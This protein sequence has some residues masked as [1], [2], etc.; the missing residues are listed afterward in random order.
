MK[1]IE[2]DVVVGAVKQVCS[3]PM[4]RQTMI[5]TES[6]TAYTKRC[7]K[8]TSPPRKTWNLPQYHRQIRASH[9]NLVEIYLRLRHLHEPKW[10]G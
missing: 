7:N 3:T 6:G 2:H 4:V 9:V 8:S 5:V 10:I 1:I